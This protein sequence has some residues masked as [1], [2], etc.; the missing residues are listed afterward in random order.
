MF[1][2]PLSFGE[3]LKD[4]SRIKISSFLQLKA[5][6]LFYFLKKFFFFKNKN[7]YKFKKEIKN[8]NF[9]IF[10]GGNLIMSKMGS[11]YGYRIARFTEVAN[12]PTVIFACGVGPFLGDGD[13]ICRAVN[14]NSAYISVRDSISKNYLN[15]HSDEDV[16]IVSIDPAFV[17]SEI[18]QAPKIKSRGIIGFNI[19]ANYFDRN[20]LIVLAK[21]LSEYLQRKGCSLRIINTAFPHDRVVALSF[22]EEIEKYSNLNVEIISLKSDLSNLASAYCDLDEFYGCRMHSLIFALSYKVPTAGFCWDE[23]VR[24]ML[25]NYLGSDFDDIFILS[26]SS[27][28]TEVSRRLSMIDYESHLNRAKSIIEEDVR[29]ALQAVKYCE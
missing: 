23:K 28:F 13:Y 21:N 19:I 3:G 5:P 11:D 17:I 6:R 27:N 8:S 10:G 29:A 25:M 12:V 18:F 24:S 7:I 4:S 14:R 16:S 20:E 15:K 1:R 22:K 26:P 9:V 2:K